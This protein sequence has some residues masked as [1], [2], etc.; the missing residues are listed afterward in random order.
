M[1]SKILILSILVFSFSQ[2]FAQEDSL[3]TKELPIVKQVV[4]PS[5]FIVAGFMLNYSQ[6][7]KDLKTKVRDKVGV[8]YYNNIDDF[9]QYVPIVQMYTADALGIKAKN[10][11]FDQTKNLAIST[12]ISGVIIQS[13]KRGMNKTRPNGAP[14]AFPS[15]H[16]GTAFTNASV[17]YQEFKGSAPVLAYSGYGFAVATGGF[18][19]ANNA[20]WLSDV[21]TSI[22][23]S[24][25]VTNLVYHYEPLKNFNPFKKTNNISL[26]PYSKFDE[27]GMYFTLSF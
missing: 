13:I 10:H 25:L 7:E 18:R 19:I 1:K 26:V 2:S 5:S 16:T 12:L 8:N 9:F 27:T 22:G 11:W 24:I 15:G 23:L 4:L 17:L 6:L 14:Y 21:T 3:N 20:H